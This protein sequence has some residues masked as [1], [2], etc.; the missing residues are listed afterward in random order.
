[1]LKVFRLPHPFEEQSPLIHQVHDIDVTLKYAL[2]LIYLVPD[3]ARKF[4]VKITDKIT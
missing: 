1:M 2:P 4:S 3:H